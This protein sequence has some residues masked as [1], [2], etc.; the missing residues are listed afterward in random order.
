MLKSRLLRYWK[1]NKRVI[2]TKVHK[3]NEKAKKRGPE[4]KLTVEQELIMV[5]LKLR[6]NLPQVLLGDIFGIRQSLCS[7]ITTTWL[8]ILSR[9]LKNLIIKPS[10]EEIK[11]CLPK[12]FQ[13]LVPTARSIIDCSEFYIETSNSLDIQAA[14]ILLS[15]L[16]T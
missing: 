16:L 6:L 15:V 1:G 8:K 9:L 10:K 13:E 14:T 3:V 4:R 11:S 2:S 12:S 5:F 7:Q